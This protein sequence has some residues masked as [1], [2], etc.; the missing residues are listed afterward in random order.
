LGLP[1]QANVAEDSEEAAS[2]APAAV[3]EGEGS[4][5]AG[6]DPTRRGGSEEMRV[7]DHVLDQISSSRRLQVE[8]R[9]VA[10]GSNG[11]GSSIGI[12]LFMMSPG[13]QS[14]AGDH[15]LTD[16]SDFSD[17]RQVARHSAP[18]QARLN[19]VR[20]PRRSESES[21]PESASNDDDDT[22]MTTV[23]ESDDSEQRRRR[24]NHLRRRIFE[25]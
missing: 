24:R 21:G 9:A 22:N 3:S 19:G 2:T 15:Y 11:G 20:R 6:R 5:S 7:I 23:D 4:S 25:I 12:P 14:N 16:A 13:A 10:W 17:R 1:R 18:G 8:A